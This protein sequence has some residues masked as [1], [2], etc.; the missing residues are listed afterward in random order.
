[1]S[2]LLSIVAIP[3]FAFGIAIAIPAHADEPA[4]GQG[5]AMS[6]TGDKV[7]EGATQVK[8]GVVE[9]AMAVK[10]AAVE[11]SG[12]VKD[13]AVAGAQQIKQDTH[14]LG[15]KIKQAAQNAWHATKGV[16]SSSPQSS[17]APQ[18]EEQK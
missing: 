6:Q 2:R 12:K 5:S 8:D 13:G 18:G 1:M 15:D 17:P 10:D 16:F 11:G 9:G 7:K 14:G 3:L 4:S